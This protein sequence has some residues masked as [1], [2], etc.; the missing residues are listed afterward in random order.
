M[1]CRYTRGHKS[2]TVVVL[3]VVCGCEVVRSRCR[4]EGCRWCSRARGL[5]LLTRAL[6]TLA[7]AGGWRRPRTK[8]GREQGFVSFRLEGT[9]ETIL[10]CLIA[11]FVDCRFLGVPLFGIW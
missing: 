2:C 4:A 3:V 11:L 8:A 10:D 6:A 7:L 5:C 1:C 9:L